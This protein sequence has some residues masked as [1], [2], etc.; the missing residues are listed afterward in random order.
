MQERHDN[1]SN[2]QK[3]KNEKIKLYDSRNNK[4]HLIIV[5]SI[6][7]HFSI[8]RR[9]YLFMSMLVGSIW[10]SYLIQNMHDFDPTWKRIAF[11]DI[12]WWSIIFLLWSFANMKSE[13]LCAHANNNIVGNPCNQPNLSY[14]ENQ[15]HTDHFPDIVPNPIPRYLI[16][17]K[18]CFLL[19]TDGFDQTTLFYIFVNST[20]QLLWTLTQ[21]NLAQFIIV[22]KIV[23]L[24]N[25]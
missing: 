21:N 14:F 23:L 11:T 3:I 19:Q 9:L 2:S 22:C 7:L 15:T 8:I 12:C 4:Q 18:S 13:K 16:L 25:T 10:F 1:K 17:P 24:I 5:I 6:S 20:G